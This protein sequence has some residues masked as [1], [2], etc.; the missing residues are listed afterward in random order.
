MHL[1]FEEVLDFIESTLGLQLF[2]YQ[3]ILLLK[4][5][6]KQPHNYDPQRMNEVIKLLYG[7]GEP[8]DG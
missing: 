1:T 3:K 4:E 8:N 7:S 5:Y 2:E 6:E